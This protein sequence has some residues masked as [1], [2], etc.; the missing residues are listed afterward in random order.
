[1]SH[2]KQRVIIEDFDVGMK[3]FGRHQAER[4]GATGFQKSGPTAAVEKPVTLSRSDTFID[5]I[6][7]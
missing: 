2:E 6:N 5:H 7:T 3:K 1:M 4:S